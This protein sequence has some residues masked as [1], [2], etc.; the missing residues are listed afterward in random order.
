MTLFT[1]AVLFNYRLFWIVSRLEFEPIFFCLQRLRAQSF[2][3]NFTIE[4]NFT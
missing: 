4:Y 1:F 2:P 3:Y